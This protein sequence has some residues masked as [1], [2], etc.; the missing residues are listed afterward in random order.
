MHSALGWVYWRGL[1]FAIVPKPCYT[2]IKTGENRKVS[3]ML[4]VI[5]FILSL[6]GYNIVNNYC[7]RNDSDE[8]KRVQRHKDE[9][10][11]KRSKK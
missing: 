1:K 11:K 4:D 8:S 2:Y 10:D 5:C 7:C 9:S 3:T 6:I